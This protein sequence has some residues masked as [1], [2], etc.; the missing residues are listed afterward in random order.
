MKCTSTLAGK[1]DQNECFPSV[2]LFLQKAIQKAHHFFKCT[3]PTR[4]NGVSTNTFFLP[5]NP[6]RLDLGMKSSVGRRCNYEAVRL[7]T[8]QQWVFARRPTWKAVVTASSKNLQHSSEF[9]CFWWNFW[10]KRFFW[11]QPGNGKPPQKMKGWFT[12][13]SAKLKMKIKWTKPPFFGF[14]PLI[15]QGPGC[16][17][18]VGSGLFR[19]ST[20]ECLTFEVWCPEL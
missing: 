19:H 15:I 1:I 2:F 10:M 12:Q 7:H 5:A 20:Q 18:C 3:N 9:F 8:T 13:K 17:G 14:Q 4:N 6:W 16:K 11:T